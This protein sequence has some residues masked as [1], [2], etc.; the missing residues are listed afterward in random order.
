M[1]PLPKWEAAALVGSADIA[2]GS[3]REYRSTLFYVCVSPNISQS[4]LR[5]YLTVPVGL[6]FTVSCVTGTTTLGH[7]GDEAVRYRP[8]KYHG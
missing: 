4:R 5:V 7:R 6:A 3:E 1:R 8:S 2:G